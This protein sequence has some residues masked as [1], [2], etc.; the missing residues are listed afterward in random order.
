MAVRSRALSMPQKENKLKS[1]EAMV[2]KVEQVE[3]V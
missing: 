1:I 3:V 2:V